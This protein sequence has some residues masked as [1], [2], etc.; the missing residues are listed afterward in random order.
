M[1]KKQRIKE[2]KEMN[3]KEK[4][5]F[6][7]M[8]LI[9]RLIRLEQRVSASFGEFVPYSETKYFTSLSDKEKKMFKNYLKKNKRR[10]HVL[11]F[12]LFAFIVG[13]IFLPKNFTSRAISENIF[14]S[15][16]FFGNLFLGGLLIFIFITLGIFLINRER[17][18]KFNA[19]FS[20]AEDIYFK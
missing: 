15:S 11:G 17:K 5:E 1:K 20:I 18:R 2:L 10:K 8:D 14:I 6:L 19:C 4:K 13:A 12:F 9:E 3:K 7:S 16:S